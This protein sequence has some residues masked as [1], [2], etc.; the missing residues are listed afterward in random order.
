MKHTVKIFIIV[1]LSAFILGTS[2]EN[3]NNTS[4]IPDYPVFLERNLN[5]EAQELRTIGGC[6]AFP[7]PEKTYEHVGFGGILVFYGL[8]GN[9][10]AYDMACPLEIKRNV[11]VRLRENG[12]HAI[13]DECGSVFNIAYGS[14]APIEGEAREGLKIY[15]VRVSQTVSG[16]ILTVTR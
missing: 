7:V 12:I 14:G 5:L 15:S 4:S 10:Y 13:C 9:Y 8:D 16:P 2:C 11:K 1:S 6:K 3:P